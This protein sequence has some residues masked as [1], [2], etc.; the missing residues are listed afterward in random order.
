MSLVSVKSQTSRS[1]STRSSHIRSCSHMNWAS[2]CESSTKPT[3]PAKYSARAAPNE[4]SSA[5][6]PCRLSALEAILRI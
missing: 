6:V 3:R 1:H 5:N 4:L 2:C